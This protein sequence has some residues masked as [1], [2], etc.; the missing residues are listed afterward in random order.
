MT[1]RGL[2]ASLLVLAATA[3]CA[4]RPNGDAIARLEARRKASP[5]ASKVLRALGIAYYRAN[6]FAD[7]RRVLDRARTLAP[8]DGVTALYLGMSAERLGDPTVA[9]AAYE[10]YVQHGRTSRVRSQLRARLAVLARRELEV[11][12]KAAVAQEASL[13]SIPGSPRTIAVLPLEFAGRDS[14]LAALGP[15]LS[16]LLI[17]DLARVS[18]LTVVERA[19]L[20]ALL[21]EVTRSA[22][23]RVDA[24]TAVRSGRLLRAGRL[25]RGTITQPDGKALRADAAVVDVATS[26]MQSPVNAD[27]AIDAVLDAEKRLVFAILAQLGVTPTP[28]ERAAIE[29]RPTRSLSAFLAYSRGIA[30]EDAG[31]FDEAARLFGEAA[32]QDPGF[33][34]ARAAESRTLQTSIGTAATPLAV[35]AAIGGAE[36][37]VVAAAQTGS[38]AEVSR[39]AGTLGSARDDLNPSPAATAATVGTV[40]PTNDGPAQASGTDSPLLNTGQIIVRVP[41]P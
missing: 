26:R 15:G 34:G 36:S 21:D 11:Q 33:S 25:V 4:A 40:L 24:A 6:R 31:R 27:F 8:S 10:S 20:D 35:E 14:S 12:A 41:L 18:Q 32:R 7:A 39:L 23:G 30:A 17:T 38:A 2:I 3:G 5:E 13:S 9:R 29:Q 22:N 1:I 19:R 37:A 28:A 16:D